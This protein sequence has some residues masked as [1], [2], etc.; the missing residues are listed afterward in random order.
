MVKY[1]TK[2]E[3]SVHNNPEDCWVSIFTDVYDLSELINENRGVLANPLIEAA[4]TSIS[5]WFKENSRDVKTFIDPVRHIEMPYT[6]FGRFIHVPPPDPM[7]RVEAIVTPWWKDNRYIIG[8]VRNNF[9]VFNCNDLL[10]VDKEDNDDQN[11]KYDDS[12]GR[13]NKNLPGR[14]HR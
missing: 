9:P 4:G 10:S 5:H 7:D 12:I 6:P 2:E 11:H 1:F 13:Y 14:N 3:I 8:K